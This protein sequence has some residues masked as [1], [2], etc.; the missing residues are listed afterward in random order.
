MVANGFPPLH[1]SLYTKSESDGQSTLAL[2]SNQL[3]TLK[4]TIWCILEEYQRK[5]EVNQQLM[6]RVTES[7][8]N[9]LELSLKANISKAQRDTV[10]KNLRFNLIANTTRSTPI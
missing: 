1:P 3:E 10:F 7:E 9:S 4:N 6:Q 8:R 5:V 2:S